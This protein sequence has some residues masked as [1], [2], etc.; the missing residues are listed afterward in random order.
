LTVLFCALFL[1]SI[2][3][4]IFGFLMISNSQATLAETNY[5]SSK[6]LEET[7]NLA[8]LEQKYAAIKGEIPKIDVALPDQKDSAILISDIDSL[9]RASG[10][11]FTNIQTNTAGKKGN[12]QSDMSLLQTIKGKYGY[13]L[14]LEIK[15]DGSFVGF[16][17]FITKLESYQRLINITS[18]DI[19]KTSVVGEKHHRGKNKTNGIFK[20]MKIKLKNN[21]S[22]S[23]MNFISNK[24][25]SSDSMWQRG[26]LLASFIVLVIFLGAIVYLFVRPIDP[27]TKTSIEKEVNSTNV[28]FDKT[29]LENLKNRQQPIQAQSPT[30]GKN[31]FLPF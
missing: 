12:A 5:K 30:I 7:Q 22:L 16:A 6:M 15:V 29:T 18:I 3:V 31:P 24:L 17:D 4:Q 25:L 27:E 2:A 13:E 28:T 11:K 8:S 23:K 9:S 19:T 1:I 20:Q 10:L 14:P 26:L 21:F